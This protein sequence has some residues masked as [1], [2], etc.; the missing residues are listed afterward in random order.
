M[1]TRRPLLCNSLYTA[2]RR[3]PRTREREGGDTEKYE[4]ERG[5]KRTRTIKLKREGKRDSKERKKEET[6]TR[7]SKDRSGTRMMRMR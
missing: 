2:G 7:T 1:P 3:F 5:E 6:S 4:R